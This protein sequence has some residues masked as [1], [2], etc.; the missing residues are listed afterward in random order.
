M[1]FGV[2]LPQVGDDHNEEDYGDVIAPPRARPE[3]SGGWELVSKEKVAS[4]DGW[5]PIAKRPLGFFEQAAEALKSAGKAIV[6]H[7]L[8]ALPGAV[9]AGVSAVGGLAE[10]AAA[11]AAGLGGAA[12]GALTPGDTAA[13][14]WTRSKE[15]VENAFSKIPLGSETEVGKALEGVL[16]LIPG[17]IHASGETVFEKTGSAL[18]G[19]GTEGLLT[20]LTLKPGIASKTLGWAY[21]KGTRD[22]PSA[23]N[24]R[25]TFD[26]LVEDNLDGAYRLADHVDDPKLK[27]EL[28]ARIDEMT[29]SKSE[30]VRAIVRDNTIR[31]S[32]EVTKGDVDRIFEEAKKNRAEPVEETAP[33]L[34]QGPPLA[35]GEVIVRGP[36]GDRVEG[37]AASKEL[38][39]V[40]PP[41]E[42]SFK[43]EPP[44]I[45]EPRIE[46]KVEGEGWEKVA[47]TKEEPKIVAP[48]VR[49]QLPAAAA[50]EVRSTVAVSQELLAPESGYRD[51]APGQPTTKMPTAM[52]EAFKAAKSDQIVYLNAGVP[53]TRA[54]IHDAFVATRDLLRQVPIL[55]KI[56]R[57]LTTSFDQLIRAVSPETLG[58]KARSAAAALAANMSKQMQHDAQ[59]TF[60]AEGRR[61]YWNSRTSEAQMSFIDGLERGATFTD[62][63]YQRAAENWKMRSRALYE[64]EKDLVKAYEPRDNYAPHMFED[65]EG[66]SRFLGKKFGAKWGEPSFLKDR[67]FALYSQAIKEGFKPKY[68]NPED[69][70]LAREHASEIAIMRAET[71]RD[72]EKMGLARKIKPGEARPSS[73]LMLD[74]HEWKSPSGD[75]YMVHPD[76]NQI[77]HNAF[78][79]PSLWT[80][81]GAVGA[82]FRG[83]M[84][85]KNILVP[86]KL[87]LSLF[88]PLHVA[89]IDTATA[90]R[91]AA[92][93]LFAGTTSPARF[94][95]ELGKALI[96]K[97]LIGETAATVAGGVLGMKPS[98][99]YRILNVWRGMVPDK[100]LTSADRLA[101]QF[102]GEGGF[103]PEM[104]REHKNN[105]I[106]KFKDALQ[107]RSLTTPFKAPFAIIEAAQKPMFQVWIPSLK[108]ASYIRDA[109]KALEVDPSL[110]KDTQKRREAFRQI[111]KSVDNNYGEMAYNT[112][113]W[114]RWVKDLGVVSSLSMGWVLGFIRTHGGAMV[115]TAK[116]VVSK[117]SLKDTV[118]RGDLDHAL[119]AGFYLANG[120]LLAGLTG[121][122]LSGKPPSEWRDYVY[123]RSGE[124]N[125]DGTDARLNTM[126]FSRE[127]AAIALHSQQEGIIKGLGQYFANKANPV[128]GMGK[129]LVTG[130]DFF[131][132]EVSDPNSPAY[133]QLQQR[134]AWAFKESLP[135]S[136][137]S[138]SKTKGTG[139][140]WA[141]G[142]AG[143]SPAPKYATES[144]T[145]AAIRNTY[146]TYN[147][148]VVPYERAQYSEE[149]KQLK[150]A[151]RSGDGE[152]YRT[153]LL[154]MKDKY[155]LSP[156]DI[157]K[158]RQTAKSDPTLGMFKRLTADQQLQIM[159]NMTPEETTKY[160]P[161]LNQKA[162]VQ[163]IRES[164]GVRG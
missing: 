140:D 23:N 28:K 55:A 100:D 9:E 119:Y 151:I 81:P 25:E 4:A 2:E 7:P 99:G 56:E 158:L 106:V 144:S 79:T 70:M 18:A 45:V 136:L 3:S 148:T 104:S 65:A 163:F 153:K 67:A 77:L 98:G 19:A 38:P 141:L 54:A 91:R 145:E 76:A 43:G 35:P 46:P 60:R 118:K 108:A 109:Q 102:I 12:V 29:V 129:G 44:P 117:E 133:M 48:E 68:T 24:V 78:N 26:T 14:G 124:K 85:L 32:G 40:P 101:L 82:A 138:I 21:E 52:E 53:V 107:Q 80:M 121:W 72:L 146:S 93:G 142:I 120:A 13:A 39:P 155:H 160:R 62:P 36:Q 57:E 47:E 6:E 154:E 59:N 22:S 122:A 17:A 131:D 69:L 147:K 88:H 63:I 95:V 66:V 156:A 27:N 64:R 126:L 111:A 135:I 50:A 97:E 125:P 61:S 73:T 5:E 150:D 96:G 33:P 16:G 132:R 41:I 20:L 110:L 10:S 30:Q 162:R 49:A 152:A 15:A 87:A 89:T 128:I 103:V 84:G 130:K 114:N 127:Y 75:R 92:K 34:P 90:M 37:G 164:Q 149:A 11:G 139:K 112:L 71:L 83:T 113:F 74:E 86:I 161:L 31:P 8:Q 143:F 1:A 159:K 105:A 115:E 157:V 94:L 116:F 123:P 42:P 137:T 58:A 134:L 51:L